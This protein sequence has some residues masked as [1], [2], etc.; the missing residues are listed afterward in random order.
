MDSFGEYERSAV[1]IASGLTLLSSW[2][3]LT[4]RQELDKSKVR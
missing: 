3:T 1:P 4:C 2:K